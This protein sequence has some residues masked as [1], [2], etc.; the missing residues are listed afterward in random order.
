MVA[1]AVIAE[2]ATTEPM[3]V[4]VIT[5]LIARTRKAALIGIWL[6]LLNFLKYL[7][8]GKMPPL[9]IAYVT[10]CADM[11]QE[12]VAHAESIQSKAR[13]VV[14]LDGPTS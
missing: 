10:R 13:M 1:V 4:V 12:A 9:E 2:K 7:L 8:P 11:K 14:V 5:T 3:T 6:F